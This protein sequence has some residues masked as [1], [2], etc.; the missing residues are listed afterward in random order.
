MELQVFS[1]RG[2]ST[3]DAPSR[4]VADGHGSDFA[5]QIIGK[6]IIRQCR[7]RRTSRRVRLPSRTLSKATDFVLR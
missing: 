5:G 3:V 1:C 6:D 7:L 4:G 2:N